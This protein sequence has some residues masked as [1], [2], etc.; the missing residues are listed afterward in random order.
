MLSKIKSFVMQSVRVWHILR[1]PSS[2]EF[3]TVA[4]VSAVGILII[5]ALGFAVSDVVKILEK[6]FG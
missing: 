2:L 6:L 3:K 4:K 1:K 5:G